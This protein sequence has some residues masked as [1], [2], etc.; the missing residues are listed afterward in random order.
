M[1]SD[2]AVGD[3]TTVVRVAVRAVTVKPVRIVPP[4]VTVVSASELAV[5]HGATE[6]TNAMRLGLLSIRLPRA[7][8][9][10]PRT[11]NPPV[12]SDVF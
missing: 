10:M 6:G 1:V 4:G 9:F 3:P 2:A 12:L 11:T 8:Q 5:Q 7:S